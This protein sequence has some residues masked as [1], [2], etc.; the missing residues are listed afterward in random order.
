MSD[1]LSQLEREFGD[2]LAREVQT[3]HE[4]IKRR[5]EDVHQTL[6]KM[7]ADALRVTRCG[8]TQCGEALVGEHREP[9]AAV[10]GA[11]FAPDLPFFFKPRNG[12]RDPAR[13]GSRDLCK[14][15][16]PQRLT[17]SFV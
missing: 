1:Q 6:E 13:L 12:V 16:H 17:R 11:Q 4:E 2:R 10:V 7:F 8:A 15:A 3:L 14:L 5:N 9:A